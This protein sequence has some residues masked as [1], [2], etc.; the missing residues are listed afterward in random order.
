MENNVV[1]QE[2]KYSIIIG[3]RQN[4]F[5]LEYL[6]LNIGHKDDPKRKRNVV[7]KKA[8]KKYILVLCK[9]EKMRI[10]NRKD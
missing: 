8:G 10:S 9:Q 5:F 4:L 3:K 7:L 6:Y 1:N 2:I